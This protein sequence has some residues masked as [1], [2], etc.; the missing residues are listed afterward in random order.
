MT[1]ELISELTALRT[2]RGE[3]RRLALALDFDGVCKLFTDHKHQIMFTGLFL[4]LRELQRVPFDEYRKTY[5]DI[6]FRSADYAGKERFLCAAAVARRLADE[7][8]DCRL[9]GLQRAVSELQAKGLKLNEQNLLA[10][11]Q[12]PDV[13]RAL[14]WSREVNERVAQLSEIGLTPGLREHILGPFET[15]ADFYVVSTATE[16]PLRASLEKEGIMFIRRYIGQETASKAEA[17]MAL[18]RCGYAAVAMFGDSVED[19]RASRA[20]AAAAP[21]EVPLVFVPVI[22]GDERRSFEAGRRILDAL[23]AGRRAEAE[24][25]SRDQE[26]AFQGREAGS[27]A[28]SPMTIRAAI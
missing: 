2:A 9:P 7:G 26:Q 22:P 25:I 8:H 28:L 12:E 10:Y 20:A 23:S 6:N 4:N 5:I 17:L 21:R 27:Q 18:S 11:G 24:T 14:T 19:A 15:R 3:P 1:D 16:A 13:A